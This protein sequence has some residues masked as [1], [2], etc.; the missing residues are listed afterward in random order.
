MRHCSIEK[1]SSC[2]MVFLKNRVTLYYWSMKIFASPTV[3]LA[4]ALL[5]LVSGCGGGGSGLASLASSSPAGNTNAATDTN[6]TTNT[7]PHTVSPL[8]PLPNTTSTASNSTAS[9]GL[10]TGTNAVATNTLSA[11][12]AFRFDTISLPSTTNIA[13]ANTPVANSSAAIGMVQLAQTHLFEPSHPFFHL[14][15]NRAALVR[16]S[17]TGAGAAPAVAIEGFVNGN[18]LGRFCLAGPALLAAT[19]DNANPDFDKSFTGYV[20]AAWMLPGLSLRLDAGA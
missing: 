20:P 9:T 14:S 17:I 19:V 3:V 11:P 5:L 10:N 1:I 7:T 15:A 6:T 16:A 2:E 4:V 12:Q 8:A 13:C 18:S